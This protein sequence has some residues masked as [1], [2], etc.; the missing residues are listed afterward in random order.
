MS[1]KLPVDPSMM[2]FSQE[3]M[4]LDEIAEAEGCTR[5]RIQ[6]ILSRAM[7]KFKQGMVQRGYDAAFFEDDAVVSVAVRTYWFD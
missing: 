7:R 1:K 5:Q 4:S 2:R 6:Q 3:A